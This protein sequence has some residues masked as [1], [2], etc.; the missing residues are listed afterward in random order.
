[1]NV[2][3]RELRPE[4]LTTL[5]I[6]FCKHD[7]RRSPGGVRVYFKNEDRFHDIGISINK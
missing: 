2:D 7:I 3:V 4:D 6:I 5:C 1:M